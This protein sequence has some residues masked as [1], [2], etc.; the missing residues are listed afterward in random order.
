[1]G[2][3]DFREK[4][5]D[6]QKIFAFSLLTKQL[7]KPRNRGTLSAVIKMLKK[8]D[9]PT[10]QNLLRKRLHQ[11]LL[12][13]FDVN[14]AVSEIR[15]DTVDAFQKELY[16]PFLQGEKIYYR[17]ERISAPSRRLVPTLLRENGLFAP[18]DQP[19]FEINCQ[20]MLDFYCG[21]PAFKTVYE[22]LY[23]K[24]EQKNM[25]PMLAFAQHYLDLSPFIDFSKSLYVALSFAM[26]G[27]E[28]FDD[29]IVLYTAFD[30]GDDDTTESVEEVNRWLENYSVNIVQVDI[31]NELRKK[32]REYKKEGIVHPEKLRKDLKTFE[33]ILEQMTPTAKLIDI[34]TNDLMKYQQGV[35]L[36]L[37]N[38][39][40]IDSK[41]LTKSVRQSFVINKYVLAKEICP[42]LQAFVMEKAP[43]YRYVC[44]LDISR[45]VRE[46]K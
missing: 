31:E 43:Q 21:K 1:M 36:L 46:E 24:A 6:F 26:K 33:E 13:V 5:K 7:K 37:N 11:K 25:Y 20:S 4:P 34:P 16:L 23:G 27:R 35:F 14:Y 10:P 29:D 3:S 19:I 17:G 15:I 30:I 18:E 22:T 28:T 42:Q 9:F 41:Y 40:L 38:F 2:A 39:S 44:L 12:D 45:A 32:G 8:E